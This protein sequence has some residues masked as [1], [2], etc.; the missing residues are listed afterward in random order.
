MNIRTKTRYGLGR[1]RYGPKAADSR[2]V[3]TCYWPETAC[4]R[5]PVSFT[6]KTDYMP[7]A[8]MGLL[9]SGT[10]KETIKRK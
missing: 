10:G 2:F 4:P 3:A 5:E 1:V 7:R 8:G 6:G 9:P